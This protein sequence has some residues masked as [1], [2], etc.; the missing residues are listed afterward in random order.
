[1]EDALDLESSGET[2]GGSNPLS[3]TFILLLQGGFILNGK[4]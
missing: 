1:M 3:G 2:R 4:F